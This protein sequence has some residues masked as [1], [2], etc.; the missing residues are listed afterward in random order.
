MCPPN[1]KKINLELY[2]QYYLVY[3]QFDFK[4]YK[5]LRKKEKPD[6]SEKQI[7]S[8]LYWQNSVKKRLK[9]YARKKGFLCDNIDFFGCGSGFN[10]SSSMEAVG[11]HV[12]KT[13]ELNGV[14]LEKNPKDTVYLVCLIC[15]KKTGLDRWL[16]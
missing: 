12:F 5:E 7:E 1:A 2:K 9:D 10:N 16:K 6:W 14:Q 8:V 11:I 3:A 15:F 4:K 13:M